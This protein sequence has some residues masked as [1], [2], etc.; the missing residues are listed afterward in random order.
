M[1][2]GAREYDGD[3]YISTAICD[4]NLLSGQFLIERSIGFIV[5]MHSIGGV[6]TRVLSM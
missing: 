1:L 2:S 6:C 3:K 4:E 5:S